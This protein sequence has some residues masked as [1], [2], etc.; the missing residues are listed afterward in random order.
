MPSPSYWPLVL[1]LGLPIIGYGFVFKN[2]FLLG[3]GVAVGFFGLSAWAV[4]PA[5]AP[6]DEVANAGGAH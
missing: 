4:E 1:A 6:E 2:W 3:V 5:T